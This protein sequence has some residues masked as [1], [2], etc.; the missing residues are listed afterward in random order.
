MAQTQTQHQPAYEDIGD[1]LENGDTRTVQ[2]NGEITTLDDWRQEQDIQNGD[3]VLVY[4]RDDGILEIVP[5]H[6]Y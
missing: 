5:P 1:A 3:E 6:L 2:S 4:Q